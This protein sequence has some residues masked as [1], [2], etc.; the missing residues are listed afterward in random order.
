MGRGSRRD[1]HLRQVREAEL[2][3]TSVAERKPGR[4]EAGLTSLGRQQRRVESL[5]WLLEV[6]YLLV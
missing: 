3:A 6:V 2:R 1:R 4:T 5:D